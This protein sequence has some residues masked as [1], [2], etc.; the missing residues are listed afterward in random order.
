MRC[1]G[2]YRVDLPKQDF[3]SRTVKCLPVR[4]DLRAELVFSDFRHWAAKQIT[5]YMYKIPNFLHNSTLG[6]LL[7]MFHC[8]DMWCL[9]L[10]FKFW[11]KFLYFW[12]CHKCGWVVSIFL[13]CTKFE[14]QTSLRVLYLQKNQ[15]S[16]L[17]SF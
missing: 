17:A 13:V 8:F 12:L 11:L 1:L 14:L 3:F 9:C 2:T 6:V 10:H 16:Y 15:V 7:W 4:K 5:V